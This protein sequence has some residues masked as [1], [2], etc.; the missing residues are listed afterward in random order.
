MPYRVFLPVVAACLV[1]VTGA[2]ATAQERP[3]PA[4]EGTFG[5]AGFVD[6]NTVH[7]KVIGA[8]GRFY[9]T[10]RLGVG[11]EITYMV[12]PGDDRDVIVTGN[13]TFDLRSPGSRATPFLVVGGGLFHHRDR[14][15]P[16]T[17]SSTEGSLTGGG[18]AR[19]WVNDRVYI[20]PEV[21]IGWEP[22]LRITVA[23]GVRLGR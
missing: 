5:W 15:G 18:G 10:P 8:A 16:S 2:P 23:V 1:L 14:F 6:D 20:A 4:L 3:R 9:L 19:V 22:H 11:P 7:H 21:R 12:G 17:F 13:L